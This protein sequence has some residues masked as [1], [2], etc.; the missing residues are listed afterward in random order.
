MA[1]LVQQELQPL[2][3]ADSAEGFA[4]EDMRAK[5]PKR[6]AHTL[7]PLQRKVLSREADRE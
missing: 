6:A 5:R 2:G 3:L 1:Q 7:V 4:D